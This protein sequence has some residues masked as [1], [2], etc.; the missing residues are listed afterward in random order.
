MDTY[1]VI[2]FETTGKTPAHGARG[3]EIAAVLVQGGRIVDQYASLM[4]SDATIPP[5]I[6]DLTGISTAMIRSAPPAA[7]VMREVGAFTQ[8]CGMVAHN[9][10]FDRHFWLA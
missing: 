4:G 6:E 9:A 2:D 7:Q 10:G 1:A 3:T 5:F 8:G